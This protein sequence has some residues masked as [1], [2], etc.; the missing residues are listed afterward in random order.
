MSVCLSGDEFDVRD[1]HDEVLRLGPVPVHVM[2][3]AVY[4]WIRA[5]AGRAAGPVAPRNT[6]L[7]A[8]VI[9]AGALPRFS[10]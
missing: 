3:W 6:L 4:R 8:A 2:E 9:L 10:A 5:Q 1:F 7:P